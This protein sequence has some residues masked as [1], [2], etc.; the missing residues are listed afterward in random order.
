M[1]MR[2]SKLAWVVTATVIAALLVST[3]CRSTWRPWW[4]KEAPTQPLRVPPPP[5]GPTVTPVEPIRTTPLIT[6]DEPAVRGTVFEPADLAMVYFEFDK[7]RITEEARGVLER[8][9]AVIKQNPG[10]IIQIEGH[11]DERGTNDYNLALG[12]RRA[13]S[14][15]DY[16][17]NLGVDPSALVTIS[18]GEE[19]PLDVGHNEEAWAKNR[20]AQFNRAQ[21]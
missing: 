4:R 6:P 9:A 8:N 7:S 11:C 2:N 3:G 20:R 1:V 17:I 12:Q 21:Q 10:V 5:P 18:Y 19:Q 13:K 14:T 15:R 16:L